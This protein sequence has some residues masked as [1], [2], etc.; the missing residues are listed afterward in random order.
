MLKKSALRRIMVSTLALI[1]V[2]IIYLFPNNNKENT[3]PTSI[4]YAIPNETPIYL[5]NEDK[6]VVRT[7]V[8]INSND[9][10]D[11]VK[12]LISALT[13]DSDTETP[14]NLE[15]IIPKNTRVLNISLENKLLK[16]SFSKEFLNISRENEEKLIESLIYT[17][18]EDPSISGIMIFIEEEKLEE[19]PQSKIKLP[20]ILDRNFGINK[21]YDITSIKD[22]EKTT[23]YY[24]GKNDDLTYFVPVTKIDNN[25]NNKVEVIIEELKSAPIHETN[26]MSYLASNVELLSYESLENQIYLSFNNA[27][28]SG[29]N[30][31]TIMEEVK[32][33]IALSLRDTLDVEEV[34]FKVNDQVINN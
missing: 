12:E 19:L 33:S 4:S 6:Y 22:L 21:V 1:I 10:L 16:V 29:L 23:V 24:I 18:T 9:T 14:K 3:I 13:I 34:I 2:T 17:L 31:N 25:K 30:T 32:Y 8:T 11:K 20:N 26:L 15:K 28:L 7:S 27:I 5:L